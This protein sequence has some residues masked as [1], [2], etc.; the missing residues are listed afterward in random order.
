M[1]YFS[2]RSNLS[3]IP[4]Q[5]RES[6]SNLKAIVVFLSLALQIRDQRAARLAC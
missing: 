4:G 1:A 3:K 6:A 2:K 5:C